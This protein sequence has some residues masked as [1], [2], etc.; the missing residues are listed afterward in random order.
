MARGVAYV[1][2]N[3]ARTYWRWRLSYAF[4]CTD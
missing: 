2:I 4:V 1:G 3:N